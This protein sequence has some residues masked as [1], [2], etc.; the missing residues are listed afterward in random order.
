MLLAM[1]FWL[2]CYLS[3][4]VYWLWIVFVMLLFFVFN[5]F[6]TSLP[7]VAYNPVA[8][9]N[10][11][12]TTIPIEDFFYNFSLLTIYLVCYRLAKHNN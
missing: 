8:I 3:S 9:T 1:A 11:R 7:V 2:K 6:L 5:Y 4:F 12:L 10:L